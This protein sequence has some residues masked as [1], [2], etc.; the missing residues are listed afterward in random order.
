MPNFDSPPRFE[1]Y[2]EIV[3]C[4]QDFLR[5]LERP[6]PTCI[7][8]NPLKITPRQLEALLAEQ[9]I[10]FEPLP[11]RS[12]AY[13]L[14]NTPHPG[15]RIAFLAGLYQIQEE[16]SMLPVEFMDLKPGQRILD[17]CAAPGSKT[18]QIA[19]RHPRGTTVVANDRNYRRMRPLARSVDRLGITNTVITVHDAS[20]LPGQIG[21][22]DR[23][24]AD[25]PCSGEGTSRKNRDIS[26]AD[27]TD[28]S[29][30]CGVQRAILKRCLELCRPGGRVVYSTCTWAPEENEAIVD[31]VLREFSPRWKLIP[32]RLPRFPAS[33]GLV[34]WRGQR[35]DDQLENALRV[36]PH[37]HDTG[38]FFVAVLQHT[39]CPS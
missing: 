11:W 12:G 16:A 15:S 23:V 31:D 13:R 26:A 17:A 35:F 8:A 19:T 1:R 20:N 4:W 5:A 34:H 39:C 10:D 38:G 32:A 21:T 24:L 37:Q 30:L 9:R 3:P 14:L 6:L 22:F 36:Y 33:P 2:R 29:N 25:V 28:F 18:T 27:E 7:W